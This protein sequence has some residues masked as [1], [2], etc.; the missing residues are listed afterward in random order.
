LLLDELHFLEPLD[1]RAI[2]ASAGPGRA[3]TRLDSTST[4]EFWIMLVFNIHN[5]TRG[6]PHTGSRMT[7]GRSVRWCSSEAEAVSYDS[8]VNKMSIRISSRRKFQEFRFSKVSVFQNS[9]CSFMRFVLVKAHEDAKRLVRYLEGEG[10]LFYT[11]K[12]KGKTGRF[13]VFF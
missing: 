4:R 6:E 10:S 2:I 5:G 1:E 3:R 9:G 7:R 11:R 12:L 13:T 8:R